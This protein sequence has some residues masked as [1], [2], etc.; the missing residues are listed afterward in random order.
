MEE[1][2]FADDPEECIES[3]LGSSFLC[4]GNL[5]PSTPVAHSVAKE[6]T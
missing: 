2:G 6:E 3:K 1:F 4:N 5:K